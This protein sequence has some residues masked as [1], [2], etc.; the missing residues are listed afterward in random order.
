MCQCCLGGVIMLSASWKP[1]GLRTCQEHL[2]PIKVT[3]A[4]QTAAGA[5]KSSQQH[6]HNLTSVG[7]KAMLALSASS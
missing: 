1:T 5:E 2:I 6:E 7:Y 3:A 4:P